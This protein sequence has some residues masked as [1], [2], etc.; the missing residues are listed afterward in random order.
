MIDMRV[1]SMVAL[2]EPSQGKGGELARKLKLWGFTPVIFTSANELLITL[3]GGRRFEILLML[4]ND[5]AVWHCISAVCRARGMPTLLLTNSLDWLSTA[6][7]SENYQPLPL[8]D[9]ALEVA[10]DAELKIRID[11]LLQRAKNLPNFGAYV[12]MGGYE[13]FENSQRVT[14]RGEEIVLQPRQFGVA[15][16]LFRNV[17]LVVPRELLWR[18]LWRDGSSRDGGRTLDVCVANVRKLL[19]LRPENGFTLRAAYGRGYQLRA[20]DPDVLVA[21]GAGGVLG[22]KR[23]GVA[24]YIGEASPAAALPSLLTN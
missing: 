21:P 3:S 22:A 17:G 23:R 4:E 9:F 24:S 14:L 16:E 13:F 18:L 15:L 5:F 7:P 2:V 12:K 8:F 20:A 1:K 6:A 11:A 19:S 10:S